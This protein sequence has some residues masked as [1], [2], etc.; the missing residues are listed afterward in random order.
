MQKEVIGNAELY[1]G[2]CLEIM[3]I[4][5]KV[6][7]VVTDPPY[8]L[9]NK[10]NGGGGGAKSNWKHRPEVAKGFD[11]QRPDKQ[12]FDLMREMSGVTLFW[13]GN[14]FADIL[15]PSMGWLVWD[16]GLEGFTTS[17]FEMAWTSRNNAARRMRYACGNE[18]GFA[19]K[20]KE[21]REF[22]NSHPTQKPV[23]VMQWCI[24]QIGSPATICDPFMGSGSTGVAAVNMGL[25]FIGCE[26]ERKYFDIACKRIEKAQQQLNL[27]GA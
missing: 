23:I 20:S 5:G 6:D 7:A 22:I 18:R 13:G 2:D 16:K 12:Y 1:H 17:D 14:Y 27:F 9:G 25:K 26:L 24:Q 3:P 15:P 4:I 10:H 21:D 11:M 19:P 8:G